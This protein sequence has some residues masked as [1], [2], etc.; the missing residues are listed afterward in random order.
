ML[1]VALSRWS[2][3]VGNFQ[4]ENSC[5][6]ESAEAHAK[7]SL[8][9]R[10]PLAQYS[11]PQDVVD[12][13][14]SSTNAIVLTGAGISTN[15]GIPDFR[16]PQGIYA[17]LQ[18]SGLYPELNDPQEM[19]DMDIFKENPEIFYSFAKE[20]Y[21]TMDVKRTSRAHRWIRR[22]EREGKLLRNYTQN[23]DT[24]EQT[25]GIKKVLHAHGRLSTARD[26]TLQYDHVDSEWL[27]R[28]ICDLF[29]HHLSYSLSRRFH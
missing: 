15:C 11:T 1:K 16:S 2:V 26:C 5:Q 8:R 21:P 3:K 20:L 9:D 12:L 17:R 19:F 4:K 28:V 25:A 29:L 14:R 23:I 7:L 22:L 27:D 10:E 13:L 24:L 18:A 6:R